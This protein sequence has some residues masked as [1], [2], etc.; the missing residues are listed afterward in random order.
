MVIVLFLK[1]DSLILIELRDFLCWI[2]CSL[3]KYFVL[4]YFTSHKTSGKF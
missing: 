1:A 4:C 2:V 3:Y